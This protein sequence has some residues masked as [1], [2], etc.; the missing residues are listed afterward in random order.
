MSKKR[1]KKA[2]HNHGPGPTDQTREATP[3]PAVAPPRHAT[4]VETPPDISDADRA[5]RGLRRQIVIAAVAAALLGGA[6]VLIQSW[7]RP[8]VVETTNV[9]GDT[10]RCVSCHPRGARVPDDGQAGHPK[11][12][13]HADISAMGCTPC[14]GG[15]PLRADITAHKPDLGEGPNPFI[16]VAFAQLSCARCHPIGNLAGAEALSQGRDVYLATSCVGCHHPGAHP[17]AIGL[18]LRVLAQRPP[19][20]VE[21]LLIDPR[22]AHPTGAMWTVTDKTYKQR[23]DDS[24]AG[25]GR[26]AALVTYVLALGDRTAR[27]QLAT[28]WADTKLRVDKPCV[29]C[30][31]RLGQ[32]A[33]GP[34][35]RCPTLRQNPTLR[36][37]RCHPADQGVAAEDSPIC[38]QIRAELF[39]CGTCHLRD[40]DG[41][42]ELVSR[43]VAGAA[44]P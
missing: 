13:G 9:L 37:A 18:D 39:G 5:R 2:A 11:I 25:R 14:H 7:A 15:R 29:S 35:H 3:P 28:S 6:V 33:D 10:E 22:T 42:A 23:F 40:G 17:R 36:C 26:L 20:F 30:H 24:D 38:P 44:R 41:A 12:S 27:Q 32:A 16:P 8:E 43:A 34:P 4:D 31:R 1:R 19:Q 21:R